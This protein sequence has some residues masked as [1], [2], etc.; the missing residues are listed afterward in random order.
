[1]SD[2]EHES[3][4]HAEQLGVAEAD[5]TNERLSWPTSALTRWIPWNW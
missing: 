3:K 2:I 4:N 5:V 1:M